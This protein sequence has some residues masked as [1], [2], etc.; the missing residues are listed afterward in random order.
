MKKI[1]SILLVLLV[2]VLLL[3][4]TGD[5]VG[6][7]GRVK[8]KLP[9]DGNNNPL[10]VASL[11]Y[12]Y[13]SEAVTLTTTGDVLVVTLPS[14]GKDL[15]RQWRK[16]M[17]RNPSSTR[18]VYLCFTSSTSCPEYN[19]K[20]PPSTTVVMDDLYFGPMNSVAAIYGKLDSSGS[21]APEITIW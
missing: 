13:F 11:G 6:T 12:S 8:Y 16:L 19:V 4:T 17:A 5:F 2:P 15:N 7:I 10:Q 1:V 20:V 9:L 21:V 18:S 3:A 14:T